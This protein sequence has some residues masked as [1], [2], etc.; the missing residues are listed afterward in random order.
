M[1]ASLTPLA[2]T[3]AALLAAGYGLI[4]A[5]SLAPATRA[6]ARGLWPIL[7]TETVIVGAVVT[8][9]WLG[10]PVLRAAL[11]LMALRVGYEAAR[12]IL[13]AR[14]ELALTVGV[15]LM[16]ASQGAATLPFVPTAAFALL[17]WGAALAI[18]LAKYRGPWLDMAVFPALPLSLFVAFALNGGAATL[19]AAFLLVEIFDSFAL[20]GGKLFGR[21]PIFPRLSPRKT[22]EGL[23]TG[24]IMLM[25]LAALLGPPIINVPVST[26]I[27][28]ACLTGILAVAGD[29]AA[30]RLKRSASVKDYPAILPHQGGLLDITDAWIATG[31]GFA[32]V[33]AL[34]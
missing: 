30:S 31:A 28:A 24:T 1:T 21:T 25:A 23:A 18:K 14:P 9:L 26:G 20:L 2:L 6:Q 12:V 22:V 8:A 27:A 34:S 13:R 4:A 5:L 7:L 17:A 15:A 33:T 19:L 16:L 11:A 3:C 29:L 32:L 10:G